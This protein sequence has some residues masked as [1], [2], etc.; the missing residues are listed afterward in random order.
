[1]CVLSVAIAAI[2]SD[3]D[4]DDDDDG[5]GGGGGDDYQFFSFLELRMGKTCSRRTL[6][7]AVSLPNDTQMHTHTHA[8]ARARTPM[9]IT[10]TNL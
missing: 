5:G 8:R 2:A 1:M 10:H 9:Y 3:D 7:D 6:V 4:D